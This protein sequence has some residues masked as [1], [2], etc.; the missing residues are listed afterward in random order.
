MPRRIALVVT[1]SRMAICLSGRDPDTRAKRGG[2]V[3]LVTFQGGRVEVR[4][5]VI[6]ERAGWS[7]CEPADPLF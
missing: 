3:G 6:V 7:R 1:P 4:A 5:D 2:Q